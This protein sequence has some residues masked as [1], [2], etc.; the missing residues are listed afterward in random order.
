M[1]LLVGVG[2]VED[3]ITHKYGSRFEDVGGPKRWSL[4]LQT[5]F[6]Q[7]LHKGK[8]TKNATRHV[9]KNKIQALFLNA[10]QV[11]LCVFTIKC[12]YNTSSNISTILATPA[13]KLCKDTQNVSNAK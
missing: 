10:G 4:S 2:G 8:K 7:L 6:G 11:D 12:K 13:S 9:V 1:V 5:H 3:T